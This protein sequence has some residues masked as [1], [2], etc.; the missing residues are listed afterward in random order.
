MLSLVEESL[1][2]M[3]KNRMLIVKVIYT[4]MSEKCEQSQ[5]TEW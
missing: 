3:L 1:H 2:G 4:A 5:L